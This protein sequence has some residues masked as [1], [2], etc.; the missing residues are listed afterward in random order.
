MASGTS[1]A[2]S[3]IVCDG[4]AYIMIA[5]GK[6]FG[7]NLVSPFISDVRRYYINNLFLGRF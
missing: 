5:T 6:N 2:N 7:K 1:C 4:E 3:G